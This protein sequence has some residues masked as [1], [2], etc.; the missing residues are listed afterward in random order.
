MAEQPRT[1]VIA[2]A[3]DRVSYVLGAL[4][5]VIAQEKFDPRDCELILVKAFENPSL[6]REIAQLGVRVE[7]CTSVELG[8]KL[9]TGIESTDAELICFLEDDDVYNPGKLAEVWVRFAD[10]A[11]GYYHNSQQLIDSAGNPLPES[12]FRAP[13]RRRIRRLGQVYL[14][15]NRT[16]A[17]LNVLT[18]LHPEFNLSSISIRRDIL[19]GRMLALREIGAAA[20][21]FLFYSALGSHRALLIDS[22]PLTAFR[23]HSQNLS[24]GHG[25]AAQDEVRRLSEYSSKVI[26]DLS[27]LRRML[28]AEGRSDLV[29]LVD[30]TI[31]LQ[32]VIRALRTD[33]EDWLKIRE[34]VAILRSNRANFEAR[35]FWPVRFL[36]N[37]FRISPYSARSLYR[38]LGPA[39]H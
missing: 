16:A 35:T 27:R 26:E 30:T 10:P 25:P 8:S 17:S 12:A 29:S 33:E 11:L 2:V 6:E 31:A 28:D 23:I 34:S 19:T 7:T 15:A 22:S 36:G 14:P 18:G 3:H 24:V 4:Q 32:T 9:A 20:D 13:A 21:Q 5:S 37:L 38:L 1:A 39:T